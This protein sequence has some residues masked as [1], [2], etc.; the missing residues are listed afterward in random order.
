MAVQVQRSYGISNRMMAFVDLLIV[1]TE[2]SWT[3]RIKHF[4]SERRE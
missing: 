3:H 4:T 2:G 1:S